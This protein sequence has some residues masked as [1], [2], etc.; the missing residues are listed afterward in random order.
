M[1]D[2]MPAV[3]SGKIRRLNRLLQL[4]GP[5]IVAAIDDALIAG[6]FAIGCLQEK[7][8]RIE[9]SQVQ[10]ILAHPG[11]LTSRM[12]LTTTKPIIANVTASL[13]GPRH[14]FK[15]QV[16]SVERAVA[17][18]ADAIAC[19]VNLYNEHELEMMRMLGEVADDCARLGYPLLSIVYPRGQT[20]EGDENF[21]KERAE[22]PL[23]YLARLYQCVQVAK[24]LGADAV[25]THPLND[26]VL[27]SNLV[28][29][30]APFPIFFSG[31]PLLDEDGLSQRCAVVHQSGASGVCFGRNIFMRDDPFLAVET[32]RAALNRHSR[33]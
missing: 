27:M 32:I 24:D 13:R 17:L 25:K 6:P 18:G 1:T 15:R 9:A 10:A 2:G 19:H 28:G 12:A 22:R 11:L 8:A 21:E 33:L 14:V 31:G 4:D 16:V 20:S 5:S 30:F 3:G 26:E 23:A 7:V 29:D